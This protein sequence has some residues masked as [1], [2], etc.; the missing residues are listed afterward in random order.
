MKDIMTAPFLTEVRKL[1]QNM[2]RLGWDERNGGNLSYILHEDELTPNL[3][4][5]HVISEIPTNFDA[6]PLA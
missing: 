4:I 2:Y 3:D 5:N 1:L 6:S